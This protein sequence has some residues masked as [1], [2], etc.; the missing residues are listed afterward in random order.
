[1]KELFDAVNC[2]VIIRW[3]SVRPEQEKVGEQHLVIHMFAGSYDFDFVINFINKR[4]LQVFCWQRNGR[5]ARPK[6]FK[7]I[8]NDNVTYQVKDDGSYC[9]HNYDL[10]GQAKY[11]VNEIASFFTASATPA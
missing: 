8:P 3:P 7:F 11:I 10:N 5:S 2:A 1:M 6:D 4:S 9:W